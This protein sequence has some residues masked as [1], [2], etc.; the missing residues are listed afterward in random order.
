MQRGNWGYGG[1]A[2]I[3]NFFE[4]C[5][6]YEAKRNAGSSF[7]TRL[8]RAP[9]S[10][11]ALPLHAGYLALLFIATNALLTG[12]AADLGTQNQVVTVDHFGLGQIPQQGLECT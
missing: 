8:H 6:P 5:S 12:V 10:R 2:P 4:Q 9:K 7:T 3:E 11:I 1:E